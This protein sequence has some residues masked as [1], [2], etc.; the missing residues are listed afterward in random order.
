MGATTQF[1]TPGCDRGQ[2]PQGR[3]P[4]GWVGSRVSEKAPKSL[5]LEVGL[6]QTLG[7]CRVKETGC[8]S[9]IIWPDPTRRGQAQSGGREASGPALPSTTP[10]PAAPSPSNTA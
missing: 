2:C 8:L 5:G 7:N 3:E 9:A 6:I 4:A 1:I 10:L